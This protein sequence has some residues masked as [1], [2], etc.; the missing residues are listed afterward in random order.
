VFAQGGCT[1][2]ES[3]DRRARWFGRGMVL[4]AVA[5]LPWLAWMLWLGRNDP[6]NDPA[7][8]HRWVM[9]I[10]VAF[11]AGAFACL[12]AFILLLFGR[13]W[14]RLLC[15]A[16]ALCLLFFYLATALIAD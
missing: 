3:L 5:S 12:A 11:V 8:H 7:A 13:G 6:W 4:L 15:S 16:T 9:R 14:K 1:L 10:E 2:I